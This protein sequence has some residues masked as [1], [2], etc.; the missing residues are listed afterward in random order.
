M[1]LTPESKLV[2]NCNY[3]PFCREH[4]EYSKKFLM[5]LPSTH[6]Y[7]CFYG[8]L[9]PPQLIITMDEYLERRWG[10]FVYIPI[11]RWCPLPQAFPE[12]DTGCAYGTYLNKK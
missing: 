11:P 5:Y 9:R 6:G 7:F 1:R 8:Y 10:H 12:P 3:C 4:T 2:A